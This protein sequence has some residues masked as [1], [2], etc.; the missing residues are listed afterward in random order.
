MKEV[1]G[2]CHPLPVKSVKQELQEALREGDELGDLKLGLRICVSVCVCVCLSS[3]VS[4][5][6]SQQATLL[7]HLAFLQF[8]KITYT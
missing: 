3:F 6:H 4:K 7:L 2:S 8:R 5:L 1:D